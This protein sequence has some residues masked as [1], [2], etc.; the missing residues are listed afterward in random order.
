AR[1]RQ[2]ATT[3]LSKWRRRCPSEANV[4]QDEPKRARVPAEDVDAPR[5]ALASRLESVLFP[6]EILAL[7][8]VLKLI[9]TLAM[10][11]EDALQEAVATRQT[12]WIKQL[13]GRFDCALTDAVVQAA[14]LGLRDIVELLLNKTFGIDDVATH[15]EVL[16]NDDTRALEEKAVMAAAISTLLSCCYHLLL[17]YRVVTILLPG[18][19]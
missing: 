3:T 5:D 9:D 4:P 10:T 8:H 16:V 12:E 17:V 7:P 18:S 15:V 2:L 14:T 1:H 6:E 11:P 19:V 13:L